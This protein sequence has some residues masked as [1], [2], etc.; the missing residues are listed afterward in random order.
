MDRMRRTRGKS[1]EQKTSDSVWRGTKIT[2]RRSY[3]SSGTKYT[4]LHNSGSCEV[5]FSMDRILKIFIVKFTWSIFP[6][7]L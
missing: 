5:V 7:A 4:R 2:L 1:R 6:V 3:R